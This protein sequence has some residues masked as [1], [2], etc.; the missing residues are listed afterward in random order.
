[1]RF[2]CCAPP[3][4]AQGRCSVQLRLD[5]RQGGAADRTRPEAHLSPSLPSSGHRLPVSIGWCEPR[6]RAVHGASSQALPR[7]PAV[8]CQSRQSATGLSGRGGPVRSRQVSTPRTT[9]ASLTLQ[10]YLPL[11]V[12]Y[13]CTLLLLAALRSPSITHRVCPATIRLST[14]QCCSCRLP[15]SDMTL[16]T[17]SYISC[18]VLPLHCIAS[19]PLVLLPAA[20]SIPACFHFSPPILRSCSLPHSLI[21]RAL[22]RRT[23][24]SSVRT[25]D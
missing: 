24:W 18:I 23:I 20:R 13:L 21:E 6:W 25:F 10:V 19:S 5:D 12:A 1:M 22:L 17:V 7:S 14:F 15:S 3:P 4:P 16:S 9:Q 2:G 8:R 11:V